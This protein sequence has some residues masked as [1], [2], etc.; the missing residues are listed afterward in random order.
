MTTST[1]NISEQP[2]LPGRLGDPNRTLKTDPRA[3]PRLVAALAPFGLDVAPPPAPVTADSPWQNKLDYLAASEA[4]LEAMFAALASDLPPI[5]QV[6]RRTVI[7]KGVDNN[8]IRLYIHLPTQASG[9]FPGVYHIH[10]G[11]MVTHLSA[12]LRPDLRI[13]AAQVSSRPSA[14]TGRKHGPARDDFGTD[15]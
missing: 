5:E 12:I 10:G 6:E 11:S 14:R 8:D 2:L 13:I 4:G 7:I 1:Q 3:H 15:R 9:P